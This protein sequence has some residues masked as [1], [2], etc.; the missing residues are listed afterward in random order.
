MTKE[1]G[2]FV[3]HFLPN[4]RGLFPVQ[5]VDMRKMHRP[6]A[7]AI[8]LFLGNA[9]AASPVPLLPAPT[10]A[11]EKYDTKH[12]RNILDF[13][14]AKSD[15]PAPLVVWFHGGGFTQGDK[16]TIAD[17]DNFVGGF[18]SR[19]VSVASCNYPYLK[20]A[21]YEE[22]MHHCAR[23]VQFLRSKGKEWNI[24]PNRIGVAGASAGALIS[25]WLGYHQDL[26]NPKDSD[27][28]ARL[29]SL[30]TAVGSYWQP[31]GTEEMI[32]PLM[33]A[34]G[35]PIIIVTGAPESDAVHHPRYARLVKSLADGLRISVELYGGP[36][37]DLPPLPAGETYTSLVLTFFSKQFGLKS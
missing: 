25:E 32:K 26:A 7:L 5:T 14:Q 36:K 24:D 29:S 12:A 20:D 8:L 27:P 4:P 9:A 31:M 3:T 15:K 13:W 16:K 22:I 6:F 34:G 28:V 30:A 23:A 19:G 18:L 1:T 11:D 17:R 33:R 35:P 2:P 37:N 21:S 10:K